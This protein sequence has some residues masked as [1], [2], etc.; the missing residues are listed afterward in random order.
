[1]PEEGGLPTQHWREGFVW[2]RESP[3][4]ADRGATHRA[5]VGRLRPEGH[6]RPNELFN[7]VCYL[8]E[9]SEV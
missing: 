9:L 7:L 4:Q 6:V 5:D 2:V 3:L 1:M 8:K